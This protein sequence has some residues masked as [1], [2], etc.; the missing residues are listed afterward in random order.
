MNLKA[1]KVKKYWNS[2]VEK[3]DYSQ[4]DQNIIKEYKGTHPKVMIDWIV[5]E[6]GVFKADTNYKLT[7]KH[8]KH[9]M[10]LK[11]EK[12]LKIDL[13]KKHFKFV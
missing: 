4:I 3:I 9:R 11:L 10:K 13:S 12:I 1:S 8:K 7:K 2:K 6:K 5:K